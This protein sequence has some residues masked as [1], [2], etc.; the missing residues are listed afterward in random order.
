MKQKNW[1]WL[2]GLQTLIDYHAGNNGIADFPVS[3]HHCGDL[4]E[5]FIIMGSEN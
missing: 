2:L 1:H 3:E 4:T 5:L